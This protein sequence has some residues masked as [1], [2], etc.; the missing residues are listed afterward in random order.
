ML[1]LE[2]HV[3]PGLCANSLQVHT[4]AARQAADEHTQQRVEHR[5][6]LLVLTVRLA[7]TLSARHYRVRDPTQ[8]LT[9]QRQ[10]VLGG[11]A[12]ADRVQKHHAVL[13]LAPPHD[14]QV[15]ERIALPTPNAMRLH[16]LD[17]PLAVVQT[18]AVTSL[19]LAVA[20][21]DLSGGEVD[22]S[23]PE[24]LRMLAHLQHIRHERVALRANSTI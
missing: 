21:L 5:L 16:A 13:Q 1:L 9:H 10:V 18:V 14:A 2:L 3:K 24:H 23:A 19:Q 11:H 17:A 15:V 12:Q 6:L 8:Q 4:A 22:Q 7:L 20:G